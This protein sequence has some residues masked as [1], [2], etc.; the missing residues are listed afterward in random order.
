MIAR[1]TRLWTSFVACMASIACAPAKVPRSAPAKDAPI[2]IALTFDDL[3]AHGD[4]PP[5]VT[6]LAVIR[7]ILATL[8]AHHVPPTYGFV[9]GAK[10]KAHPEDGEVLRAWVA[11]GQ[12]LGNHGYSHLSLDEKADVGA[13]LR[14]ID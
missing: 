6:R 13:Y 8:A 12:P 2:R 3:P 4:L 1:R 14:D 9:N 10:V 11:A 7:S 5:D